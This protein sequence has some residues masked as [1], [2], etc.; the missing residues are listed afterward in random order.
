MLHEGNALTTGTLLTIDGGK[1]TTGRTD[2]D[3][4]KLTKL[5]E[6]DDIEAYLTT[7]ER[8]MKALEVR[9]ERWYG[10]PLD[11]DLTSRWMV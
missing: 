11:Q 7:F 9:R 2:T 8:I 3:S 6:G 10:S 5:G 1:Y 4:V